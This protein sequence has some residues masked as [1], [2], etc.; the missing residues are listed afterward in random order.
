MLPVSASFIQRY[1]PL[2]K[3]RMP[4]QTAL[5]IM[6]FVSTFDRGSRWW[7][8]YYFR[9]APCTRPAFLPRSI[10]AL[11]KGFPFSEEQTR[12]GPWSE[13]KSWLASNEC[14]TQ[15]PETAPVLAR[16]FDM[17]QALVEH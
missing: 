6:A 5:D 16:N 10:G 7:Q 1:M 11:P 3:Q 9:H 12:Y 2:A 15:N 8:D 14:K 13:I 17:N 4:K